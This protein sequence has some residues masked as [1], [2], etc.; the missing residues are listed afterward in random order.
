M[1]ALGGFSRKKGIDGSEVSLCT[2]NV[3][4]ELIAAAGSSRSEIIYY[5]VV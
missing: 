2:D 1:E 5:L 3:V 4:S